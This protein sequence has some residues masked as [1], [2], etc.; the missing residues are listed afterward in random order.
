[1]LENLVLVA[2]KG[3]VVL[4]AILYF[5]DFGSDTAFIVQLFSNCHVNYG[6]V[7]SCLILSSIGVSMFF[8]YAVKTFKEGK[9]PCDCASNFNVAE[10][11][12]YPLTYLKLIFKELMY[13]DSSLT[14]S[15]KHYTHTVKF[16][17]SIVE[18]IPQIGLSFYIIHHHG[19]DK[20][21]FTEYSGDLQIFCLFG[22]IMSVTF[23]MAMRRAWWTVGNFPPKEEIF[24]AMLWNFVPIG[25]FITTYSIFM[26]N[27]GKIILTYLIV[28][29][30]AIIIFAIGLSIFMI[31]KPDKHLGGPYVMVRRSNFSMNRF[32]FANILAMTMLHTIQLH[33]IGLEDQESLK[34]KPFDICHYNS[35]T[36]NGKINTIHSNSSIFILMLW[37]IVIVALLHLIVESK[38]AHRR[39][40]VFWMFFLI[41]TFNEDDLPI[42]NDCQKCDTYAEE[43]CHL[44]QSTTNLHQICLENTIQN[45]ASKSMDKN[46]FCLEKQRPRSL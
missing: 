2:K 34:M 42:E 11:L 28:L 1:M 21:V 31:G 24:K 4:G 45:V 32:L 17:E 13:G 41:N 12:G 37:S 25:C 39:T 8:P 18:S 33:G 16:F 19:W 43:K 20:P 5:Y 38:M 7:S 23:N 3:L 9:R 46:D 22:S 26:A 30:L 35:T 29:V 14:E 36:T 44:N 10:S 6:I 15:E 40:F 27:P